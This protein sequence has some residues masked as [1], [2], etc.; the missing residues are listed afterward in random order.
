M[1][2]KIKNCKA[3]SQAK[4]II[5]NVFKYFKDKNEDMANCRL[6][7][8]TA[9]ATGYSTMSVRRI[10]YEGKKNMYL[11]GNSTLQATFITPDKKK[12]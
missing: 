7:T 2:S 9:E 6:Y 11:T 12:E 4:E 10:V 3:H 5:W 8:M 1:S